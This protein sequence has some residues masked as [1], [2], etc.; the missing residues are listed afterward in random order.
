MT[1]FQIIKKIDL[2]GKGFNFE[3]EGQFQY[4]TR[5][6]G[7]FT[8]ML[9]ISIT[10]MGILFGQEVVLKEKPLVLSSQEE[11]KSTDASAKIDMKDF[12][13]FIEFNNLQRSSSVDYSK[14]IIPKI[15]KIEFDS[16]LNP[17]YTEYTNGLI[18]CNISNFNSY[19]DFANTTYNYLIENKA[20]FKCL[21]P[22]LEFAVKNLE[23]TSNSINF[24]I[25]FNMC[26]K[27]FD[28]NC[29]DNVKEI[30]NESIIFISYVSPLLNTINLNNP[31]SFSPSATSYAFNTAFNKHLTFNL[32]NNVIET[33]YG[34]ILEEYHN[35]IFASIN[36]IQ[37]TISESY[38]GNEL[39]KFTVNGNKIFKKTRRTYMKIQDLIAKIGGLFNG[40]YLIA[41]ILLRLY[42]NFKYYIK[43]FTNIVLDNKQQT[44]EESKIGTS[45]HNQIVDLTN[46]K[47]NY[48]PKEV[49]LKKEIKENKL[50]LNKLPITNNYMMNN[51]SSYIENTGFKLIIKKDLSFWKYFLS[52]IFCC[53]YKKERKA[54][55]EIISF[56]KKKTSFYFYL[57]NI[58]E[59]SKLKSSKERSKDNT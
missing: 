39:L 25:I 13:I 22:D 12:P 8:I 58:E 20:Y 34:L 56:A 1:F 2:F 35:F 48:S 18:D 17:N 53:L 31:V 38:G 15:A 4:K 7:L 45:D 16:N 24:L 21:N 30:V 49:N 23:G 10:V 47:I 33:D 19:K 43:I 32:I 11:Y 52:Q 36:E 9:L 29:P 55:N 59:I 27:M 3:E 50:N 42:V 54:Y 57:D 41:Y 6:G 28:E 14:V 51:D 37:Y 26:D 40:L 44:N 46:K 5:V